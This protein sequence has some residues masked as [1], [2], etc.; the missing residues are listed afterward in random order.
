MPPLPTSGNAP[1]TGDGVSL[2]AVTGPLTKAQAAS[3]LAL[4][5]AATERDSVGPLSEH[6]L[7]HVRYGGDAKA[8]D[9]LLTDEEHKTGDQMLICVSRSLDAELVLDL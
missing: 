8:R 1:A 4:T 9:L 5:E 6:T 2:V 3:V 7:L